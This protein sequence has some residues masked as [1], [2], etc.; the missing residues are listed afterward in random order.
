MR[1][2]TEICICNVFCLKRFTLHKNTG[3]K[4]MYT[5]VYIRNAVLCT[6]MCTWTHL[7]TNRREC[8]FIIK[9]VFDY[10]LSKHLQEPTFERE[11]TILLHENVYNK[12]GNDFQ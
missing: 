1:I 6:Q 10:F 5:I 8:D 9:A 4:G 12:Y 3:N 2:V 11:R 7:C